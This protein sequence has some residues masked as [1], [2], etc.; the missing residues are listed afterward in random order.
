MLHMTPAR[1]S[2]LMRRHGWTIRQLRN[3]GIFA[4]GHRRQEVYCAVCDWFELLTGRCLFNRDRYE[5][6]SA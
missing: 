6:M 2:L 1:F 5:R 3:H 4:N